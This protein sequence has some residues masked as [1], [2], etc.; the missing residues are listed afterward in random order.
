M[1]NFK[2]LLK[3]YMMVVLIE[4]GTTFSNCFDNYEDL[5]YEEEQLLQSISDEVYLES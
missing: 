2:T 5:T 1:I 3:K 4:E